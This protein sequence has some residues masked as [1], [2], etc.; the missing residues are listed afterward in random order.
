MVNAQD[1]EGSIH[2]RFGAS[3]V[4]LF[5]MSCTNRF[6][7]EVKPC[8]F[9]RIVYK[10]NS[11]TVLAAKCM[12]CLACHGSPVSDSFRGLKM[13]NKAFTYT[14]YTYIEWACEGMHFMTWVVNT[15]LW[16]YRG[17]VR[18]YLTCKHVSCY[19]VPANLTSTG[20]TS[21]EAGM[22]FPQIPA[23]Y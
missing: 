14:L 23:I 20:F 2:L 1:T 4:S 12:H 11:A 9:V 8:P 5:T 15:W 17:Q 16:G 6:F 7:I 19:H 10:L 13:G 18:E 21:S 22:G 3:P